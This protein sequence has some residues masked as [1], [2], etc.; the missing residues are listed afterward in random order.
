[1]LRLIHISRECNWPIEKLDFIIRLL[2]YVAHTILLYMI[3]LFGNWW[4]ILTVP[5]GAK[6][7]F[8]N[9]SFWILL[10]FKRFRS[11]SLHM[12]DYLIAG[13]KFT[14]KRWKFSTSCVFCFVL[15][16]LL[17]DSCLRFVFLMWSP[18]SHVS[19]WIFEQVLGE[20][21]HTINFVV[22]AK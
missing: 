15:K 20:C 19:K 4:L 7:V 9:L 12:C 16:H 6:D 11:L 17:N 1:M 8:V 13:T 18:G 21:Q 14:P 22:F 2:W 3:C 5:L 10:L